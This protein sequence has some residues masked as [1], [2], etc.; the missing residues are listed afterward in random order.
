MP[1]LIRDREPPVTAR[2]PAQ[3]SRPAGR[4][5]MTAMMPR[6]EI[7]AEA[8]LARMASA[9]RENLLVH[10]LAC[11]QRLRLRMHPR[12]CKP[13]RNMHQL[14]AGTVETHPVFVVHRIMQ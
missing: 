1:A 8:G 7:L 9:H 12:A 3:Q 6:G 10:A 5:L 2:P 11:R 14:A 4:G 13:F